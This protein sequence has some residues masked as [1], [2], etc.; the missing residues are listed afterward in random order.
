[1]KTEKVYNLSWQEALDLS[2]K[3][4]DWLRRRLDNGTIKYS[5]YYPRN[6]GEPYLF[7]KLS[8][9]EDLKLDGL[10]GKNGK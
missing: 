4:G 7:D 1:M 9:I 2:G 10:G 5:T 6:K 8:L 3:S